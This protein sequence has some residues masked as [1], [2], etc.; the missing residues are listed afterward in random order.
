MSDLNQDRVGAR[1]VAGQGWR[2]GCQY[3][4][5]PGRIG[6]VRF[7]A[8]PHTLEKGN[9][10]RHDVL[11]YPGSDADPALGAGNGDLLIVLYPP[12]GRVVRM[13]P[14]RLFLSLFEPWDIF[15]YILPLFFQR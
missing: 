6:A 2:C 12:F 10:A 9:D 3:V 14:Q 4:D 8:G 11:G 5:R 13:Y 1:S 15:E 7:E